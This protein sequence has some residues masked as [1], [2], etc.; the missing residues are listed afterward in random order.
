MSVLETVRRTIDE[1]RMF[2]PGEMVVVGVSGGPD[3]LCLLHVLRELRGEYGIRLHVAHLD[4]QIRGQESADDAAFVAR[5]AEEWGIPATIATRD[6]P[7]YAR[8]RRL[9]IEEAARQARYAFLAQVAQE[10]GARKVAVAHNA[11]DQVESVLMHF[12][13]GAGLAG[14]RGMQ[15]ISPWPSQPVTKPPV[16]LILLRPLLEVP[17]TEIEAYCRQHHLQPRFDRSNL[18]TTYYRNRLR[19]ELIPLLETYNPGVRE[20]L[21]RSAKV[22]ADDYDYLRNQGRRAWEQVVTEADGGFTFAL[23]PWR[24][25]HPSLQRQLLREAIRRLRRG[26]RNINWVHIEDALKVIHER[27]TGSIAT[28]PQGLQLFKGYESFT[29]G[30]ALPRPDLPLLTVERLPLTIPGA[31]PLPGSNWQVEARILPRD[32]LTEEHFSDANPWQTVLDYDRA[33]PE[34]AL[35]RRRPGDRFQPLGLGGREKTV[36]AFMINEKIPAHI[37]DELPLVV[38]PQHIVW[39]PGWRLDERVKITE[40]TERVLELEFSEIVIYRMCVA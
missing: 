6:V 35:R 26:L 22:I 39:I 37:R 14:L 24:Q 30:E 40:D 10:V 21:R 23:E 38:S 7:A 29:V 16:N 20:V 2:D 4:H 36:S 1:H 28:L 12:L 33:G 34:L 31:T 8:E 27:P 19:H 17:R 9:A 18:D 15:P 3:S 25:L 11:D 32:E 13:R 5:I